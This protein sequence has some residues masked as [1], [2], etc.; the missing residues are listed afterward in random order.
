VARRLAERIAWS[1]AAVALSVWGLTWVSG[2]AGTQR[3]LERFHAL[4]AIPDFA[5]WSPARIEA[6]RALQAESGPPPVGVLRIP[7]LR[8]EAPILEGTDD[9]T[10]NRGLGHIDGTPP[11]G[12]IGNS[13]IAGH[14]DSFFRALKDIT[15]GDTIELETTQETLLYRVEQTWIVTPDDV[16]V[17]DPTPSQTVTLVTCHPFYF[18]GPAPKRFIVRAVRRSG[19]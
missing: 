5:L 6:W 11:P 10:L 3:E 8:V 14:R 2:H 17:L 4:R 15:T 1:V 12:A 16:W 19:T 7:R 18:I 13:G 9:A